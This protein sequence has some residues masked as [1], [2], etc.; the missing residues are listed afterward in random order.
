MLA[1]LTAAI[2]GV[3]CDDKPS[4]SSTA[5]P[6][7]QLSSRGTVEVTARLV[8]VPDGAIFKRDLYDYATILKYKVLKV[9]R[10]EVKGD[11]IY[12]GHY[13]PF[14]PRREASDKRVKEIGGNLRQFEAGQ[15]QRMA[16]EAP[17]D[18]HFMGGIVNKY[19]GRDTAPIYWAVW[20]NLASD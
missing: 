15:V 12:V 11:V 7:A 3:S 13:N 9:H 2:F 5:S 20:T 6:D 8:E 1:L 14:K 10:G 18:D 16:L 19:F 4:P 17:I